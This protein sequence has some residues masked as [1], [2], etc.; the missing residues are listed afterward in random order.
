MLVCTLSSLH[1]GH[2][3]LIKVQVTFFFQL[4]CLVFCAQALRLVLTAPRASQ[5]C[6]QSCLGALTVGEQD[7]ARFL[8]STARGDSGFLCS[9]DGGGAPKGM[10]ELKPS[11]LE[12]EGR[13]RAEAEV[14]RSQKTE[15]WF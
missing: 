11:C 6:G 13:P 15:L 9:T 1:Q 2:E 8:D 4:Y 5:A 12:E 7:T 10:S 14:K 3:W